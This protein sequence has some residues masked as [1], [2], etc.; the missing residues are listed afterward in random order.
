M[1]PLQEL[2]SEQLWARR[3]NGGVVGVDGPGEVVAEGQLK[4]FSEQLLA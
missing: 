1:S 3:R 2:G 4:G